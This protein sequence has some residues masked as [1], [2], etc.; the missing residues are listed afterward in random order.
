MDKKWMPITAGILDI[1]NGAFGIFVGLFFLMIEG[2][3]AWGPLYEIGGPVLIVIGVLAIV[4]SVFV[5]KRKRWGLALAGVIFA[6]TPTAL[7]TYL[8]WRSFDPS[9]FSDAHLSTILI[10]FLWGFIAVPAIFAI[11]LTV[12]SRKQFEGR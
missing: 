8:F 4:G 1:L 6:I 10:N 9:F 11:I 2:W 7:F 12:L 5:F 3:L